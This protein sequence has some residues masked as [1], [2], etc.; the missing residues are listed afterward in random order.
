MED[1]HVMDLCLNTTG[2]EASPVNFLACLTDTVAHSVVYI[3][4]NIVGV[5]TSELDKIDFITD[6][7]DQDEKSKATL[8][9]ILR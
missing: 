2:L 8:T 5:L 4:D 7:E 3:K 1:E 9:Y 6:V